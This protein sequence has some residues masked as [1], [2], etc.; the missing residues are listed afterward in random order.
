MSSDDSTMSRSGRQQRRL[1]A[2]EVDL[3][4]VQQKALLVGT[5]TN[6]RTAELAERSLEEL[7]IIVLLPCRRALTAQRLSPS[8]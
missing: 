4:V 8:K 1:T 3:D 6:A 2:S 7:E 5:A